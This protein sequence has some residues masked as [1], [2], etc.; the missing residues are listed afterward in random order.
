MRNGLLV[1]YEE[2]DEIRELLIR[3]TLYI[4]EE[5]V[6]TSPDLR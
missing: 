4:Q 6:V 1:T 2:A 5:L 3:D